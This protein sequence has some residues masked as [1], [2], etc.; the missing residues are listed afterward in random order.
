ME[1]IGIIAEYNPFHNGHLYH[2]NE[3]KKRYPDSLII[4]VLNGYFLERG[5]ISILSKEDKTNIALNYGV[6]IVLE[7]PSLFGTQSADIFASTSL[8]ILNEFKVNRIIFGSEIDDTNIII[9][10]ANK[11]LDPSFD[12]KVKEYLKKGINYPTSLAKALNSKFE[13]TPNDLLGISYA[14]AIL[15]N[16][17]NIKIETIKRT[18]DY[19][20]TTLDSDIVSA[21]NIRTRIQNKETIN[22]YLPKYSLDKIISIDEKKLFNLIKYNI[23]INNDLNNILDV[24]EGIDNLIKEKI[25]ECNSIDNLIK[26]IKSKRYTYNKIHR[27]LIHILLNITKT[28]ALEDI[29]YINVL[30]FDN[31]GK[32]YISF[33]KKDIRISLKKDFNSIQYKTEKNASLIYDIITNSNTNLFESLNKPIYKNTSD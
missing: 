32:K 16:K 1:V 6:N 4:L 12:N 15:Q 20:D 26:S 11:Q 24:N 31:K 17:Y 28:N 30:G 10:I 19:H 13:Y 3:I 2:I 23:I 14:K 29:S 7:L 18:N 9:E 22:K 21:T 8:K 5:D 27:M 33:I 25:Y